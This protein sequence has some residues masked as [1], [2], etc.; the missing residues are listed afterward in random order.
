MFDNAYI[1]WRG[2]CQGKYGIHSS[3]EM[4]QPTKAAALGKPT[5]SVS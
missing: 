1:H 3:L 5:D 2:N 4:T